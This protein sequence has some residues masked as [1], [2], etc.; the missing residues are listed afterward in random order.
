MV[1]QNR[2]TNFKTFLQKK[3]FTQRSECYNESKQIST[4]NFKY[5]KSNK[6]N[7]K[8]LPHKTHPIINQTCTNHK[9]I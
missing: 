9:L 5:I 4:A 6:F 7:F 1:Y 8:S 2:D 3:T